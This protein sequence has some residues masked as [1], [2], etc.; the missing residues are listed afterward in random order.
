MSQISPFSDQA[1]CEIGLVNENRKEEIR[2]FHP[3]WR[4][5]VL[6]EEKGSFKRRGSDCRGEWIAITPRRILLKWERWDEE[7]FTE[8]GSLDGAGAG[9]RNFLYSKGNFNVDTIFEIESNPNQL[10]VSRGDAGGSASI[11]VGSAEKAIEYL[12]TYPGVL[13]LV[14][15][16]RII[17]MSDEQ[18][19]RR[20]IDEVSKA[21]KFGGILRFVIDLRL[22]NGGVIDCGSIKSFMEN[23]LRVRGFVIRQVSY[24]LSGWEKVDPPYRT[25][26]YP[27]C[28]ILPSEVILIEAV[29]QNSF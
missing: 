17:D 10:Y 11:H 28:T 15:F 3:R 18:S 5:T 12:R 1:Q 6:L 20:A 13:S 9:I 25:S 22:R 29:N 16:D 23:A 2:V 21:L 24:F 19:I 26:E 14:F 27:A 8:V 4:D 7:E